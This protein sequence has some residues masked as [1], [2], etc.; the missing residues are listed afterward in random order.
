MKIFIFF[1][2]LTISFPSVRTNSTV[3]FEEDTEEAF[4]QESHEKEGELLIQE[5][6]KTMRKI[7]D[8]MPDSA[9]KSGLN[10][11]LDIIKAQSYNKDDLDAV[12]SGN[13]GIIAYNTNLLE[14]NPC[15]ATMAENFYS[16]ILAVDD[17]I[18]RKM[19]ERASPIERPNLD[20]ELGK[21]PFTHIQPGW[22]YERAL[23]YAGND[24]N[25]AMSLIGLCGHDDVPPDPEE[26][27]IVCPLGKSILYFPKALG[28][29]VDLT[30]DF[31]DRIARVQAP[32][33]GK[34]VLPAKAYHFMG[35]ALMS[36]QLVS[37]GVSPT[38]AVTI[39]K[40]AGWAYRTQRMDNLI[41]RDI[42][43]IDAL[44]EE[45]RSF[46]QQFTRENRTTIQTA[47]GSRTRVEGLPSFEEWLQTHSYNEDN[48][49]EDWRVRY[50]AARVL[51]AMT[52]GGHHGIPHTNIT[53]NFLN[54]PVSINLSSQRRTGHMR[55]NKVNRFGWPQERYD[56]AR[57][58]AMTY[59][60]DWEWTTKQHEIGAAFGAENCAQKPGDFKPDHV[61]C[62]ILG[63]CPSQALADALPDEG[64]E[65]SGSSYF[66][67]FNH[68]NGYLDE[69]IE[70][71]QDQQNLHIEGIY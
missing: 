56:R 29:T 27:G 58:K 13:T 69:N 1:L 19:T 6:D 44:E 35:S 48:P 36:C 61:A 64:R 24:A 65:S 26:M 62:S 15:F 42:A 40:L 47:R 54:D 18:K 67:L 66:E 7:M 8:S 71:S 32:E 43:T 41:A 50:D 25:I 53:L 63:E 49:F 39:Q 10:H 20:Q 60:I 38:L 57:A 31:K 9:L 37:K 52:V 55:H 45:Y 3:I 23:E 70:V 21:E 51:D 2:S 22:V 11:Y 16:E 4:L 33:K 30:E 28:E 59:L 46:A 12:G 68:L 17:N 14:R 34:S 5:Y